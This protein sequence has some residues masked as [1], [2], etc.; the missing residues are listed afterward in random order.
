[1]L[2]SHL[3]SRYVTEALQKWEDKLIGKRIHVITDHKALEFFKTQVRL[4]N[5]QQR[6]IEYMSKFDFNITYVKGEYNKVTDCLSQYYKSDTSTDIHEY[7]EYVQADRR[8]DPEGEDLPRIRMM[9]IKE[10]VVEIRTMHA[11]VTCRSKRLLDI[12]EQ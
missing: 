2:G 9:E 5:R 8:L 12:K 6:W 10:R 3:M 11:I 7:H 4:S 1:V